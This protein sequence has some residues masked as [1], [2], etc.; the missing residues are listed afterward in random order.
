MNDTPQPANDDSNS[1]PSV[2]NVVERNPTD[3]AFAERLP[4]ITA[5]A[6][7]ICLTLFLKYIRSDENDHRIKLAS[8]GY[9]D[10]VEIWSGATWGLITSAFIHIDA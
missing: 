1:A 8:I 4:W 7:C 2:T 10:A 5:I 9:C 6:C 3:R